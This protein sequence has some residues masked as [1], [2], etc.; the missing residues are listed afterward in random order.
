MRAGANIDRWM[1]AHAPTPAGHG[2]SFVNT[3]NLLNRL[4][5]E[6]RSGADIKSPS[7]TCFAHAMKLGEVDH[8]VRESL[9]VMLADQRYY[10]AATIRRAL[11][12]SRRHGREISVSHIEPSEPVLV[13]NTRPSWLAMAIQR[14]M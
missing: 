5:R 9:Q 13:G 6:R 8:L 2:L 11:E 1:E 12:L 10:D 14:T 7:N 4:N 3:V